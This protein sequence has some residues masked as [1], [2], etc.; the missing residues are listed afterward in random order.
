MRANTWERIVREHYFS[1]SAVN[2]RP[3]ELYVREMEEIPDVVMEPLS[4]ISSKIQERESYP[5]NGGVQM[6]L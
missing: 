5:K 4:L 1:F 2:S 6:F 3:D